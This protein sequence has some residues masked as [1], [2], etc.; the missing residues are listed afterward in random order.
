MAAGGTLLIVGHDRDDMR[1]AI[2]RAH[3][4][5]MGWSIDEIITA[6]GAGW[7]IE[8]AESRPRPHVDLDGNDATINDTILRARRTS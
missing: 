6:L 8:V 1:S 5:D 3:L 4:V 7:T 2:H